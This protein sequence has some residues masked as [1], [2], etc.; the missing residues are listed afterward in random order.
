MCPQRE[1]RRRRRRRNEREEK[2]PAREKDV[3]RRGESGVVKERE[4]VQVEGRLRCELGGFEVLRAV[5]LESGTN[6]K[7]LSKEIYVCEKIV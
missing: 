6:V 5:G 7:T 3:F 1:C 4:I 2:A